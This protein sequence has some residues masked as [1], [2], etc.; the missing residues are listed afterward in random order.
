MSRSDVIRK[1]LEGVSGKLHERGQADLAS[2]G[3]AVVSVLRQDAEGNPAVEMMTIEEAATLL[4]VRSLFTITRWAVEG[5]LDG[6]R[7]G[8]QILVTRA[9]VERILHTPRVAQLRAVDAELDPFDAGDEVVPRT[10][11]SGRRPWEA[12]TPPSSDQ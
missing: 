2:E 7:R 6:F 9:S 5:I 8:N 4:G 10:S 3:D 1:A 12:S 11:W